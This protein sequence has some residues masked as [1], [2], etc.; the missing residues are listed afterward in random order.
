VAAESRILVYDIEATNL[1]ADFGYVLAIGYKWL[2]EPA[3]STKVLSLDEFPRYEVDRTDDRQ[4]LKA[5]E[6]VYL[7]ADAILHY[8]GARYDEPYVNTRRLIHGMDP[9]PRRP[10]IDLLYT[11]K[12]TFRM[13]GKS[14]DRV[15]KTLRT[16]NQKSPVAGHHWV[17]AMSGYRASLQY[18]VKHCRADVL[19]LEEVY[20]R[21]RGRVYNHPRV[22]TDLA[23]CRF[24]GGRVISRGYALTVLKNRPRRVQC[25]V[26]RAW[27]QRVEPK[28]AA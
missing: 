8:N 19:V 27:D 16:K 14:L 15:A 10:R 20:M 26:C 24:C 9:L 6:K 2:G 25:T 17:R 18:I 11:A 5:F 13:R 23:A 28:R 1:D 22:S 3:S 7:Q 4:I 21:L 12:S